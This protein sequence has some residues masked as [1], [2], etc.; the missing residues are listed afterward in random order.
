MRRASALLNMYLVA[1]YGHGNFVEACY[2]TH[3]YLNHRLIEEKQL[4]LAN[5]LDRTQDFLLQLSG[6]KDVH[7]TG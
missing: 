4:N 2:G 3:F 5:V 1:V 7:Q 6:V